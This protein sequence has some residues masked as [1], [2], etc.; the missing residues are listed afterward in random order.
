MDTAVV[1]VCDSSHM[2][3]GAPT[4]RNAE[5]LLLADKAEEVR[6]IQAA[7]NGLRVSVVQDCPAVLGFLRRQHEY[8]DS[9]RPNL[10]LLNL[11]LNSN[12][13]CE[14]LREIKTDPELRRIPLVALVP[15]GAPLDLAY[16]LRANA[17]IVRPQ[18]P[19]EFVRMIRAT[20]SFWLN[21]ARLPGD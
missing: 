6:L 8:R 14:T 20:L 9:P 10:I 3:A 18:G 21:L 1:V 5:V 19:E 4:V 2:R 13:H 17:C 15:P 16:E 11:D 12:E 7:A